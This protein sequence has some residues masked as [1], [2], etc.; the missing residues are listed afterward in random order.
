V[1]MVRTGTRALVES[2]DEGIRAVTRPPG[3]H[4]RRRNPQA[5]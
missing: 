5:A 4:S 3:S 2:E 1:T